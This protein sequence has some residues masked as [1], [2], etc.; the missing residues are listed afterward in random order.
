MRIQ[1]QREQFGHEKKSEQLCEWCGEGDAVETG[2]VVERNGEYGHEGCFD[3][4]DQERDRGNYTGKTAEETWTTQDWNTGKA[5]TT[6][7]GYSVGDQVTCQGIEVVI[8][9][10]PSPGVA[11]VK[12]PTGRGWMG[13]ESQQRI[14]TFS[15]V[16]TATSIGDT[17]TP[18]PETATDEDGDFTV[19]SIPPCPACG[20][21]GLREP[22]GTFGDKL[23]CPACNTQYDLDIDG[24][25]TLTVTGGKNVAAKV[26]SVVDEYESFCAA[27]GLDPN[28]VD[29]FDD[30]I[31]EVGEGM[32]GEASD[33]ISA[34]YPGTDPGW[35]GV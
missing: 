5:P 12:D 30:W 29:A 31:D 32:A 25:Y 1:G 3:S 9:G 15:S 10:F 6:H 28:S 34:K 16:K 18:E 8:T 7:R 33:P 22:I 20:V 27:N 2:P 35:D 21:G 13:S 19:Y 14:E 23:Y 4:E 24:D 17:F 11:Y 26:A